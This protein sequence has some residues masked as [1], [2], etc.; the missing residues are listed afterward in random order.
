MA[1]DKKDATEEEGKGGMNKM[2]LAGVAVVLLGGG[3]FG[4]MKMSAP[5]ATAAPAA[6]AAPANAPALYTGLHPAM[7]VNFPDAFGDQ[8][9]MQI[10][11]EVMARDQKIIDAVKEHTA[12]IRSA[13]ILQYSTLEYE[14]ITTREGKQEMLDIGLAEVQRVLAERIGEPNVEALYFNALII[15]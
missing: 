9:F 14:S 4:Y 11:L 8:H 6:Q 1:K 15:Q 3:G 10:E 5:A 7:V 2:L 12:V 13:L